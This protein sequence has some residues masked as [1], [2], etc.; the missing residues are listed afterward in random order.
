MSPRRP[1]CRRQLNPQNRE[2]SNH[3]LL[4]CHSWDEEAKGRI[5]QA[6][7]IDSRIHILARSTRQAELANRDYWESEKEMKINSSFV[8]GPV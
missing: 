4:P 6:H 3:Y 7:F 5:R 1:L 2:E 8:L